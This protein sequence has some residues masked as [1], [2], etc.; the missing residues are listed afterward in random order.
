[1]I[2][3]FNILKDLEYKRSIQAINEA[4]SRENKEKR[5]NEKKKYNE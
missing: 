2:N 3:C 4:E 5:V 1:M